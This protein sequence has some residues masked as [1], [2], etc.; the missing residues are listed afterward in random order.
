MRLLKI[1]ILA[2]FAAAAAWAQATAQIHGTVQDTSG[3]VIADAM[4]K[5]TQTDT[6]ISR[7]VTSAADGGYV[8]TNLPLGPYQIEVSKQGFATFV[9]TG[10]V[11]QVGSNPAV[12]IA[13]KIGAVTERVNV[14]A[15][16]T[17][18]E[19]TSAGVGSVV[20][21]QRIAA[22]PLN[23]RNPDDLIVLN[24]AAVLVG[25]NIAHGMQGSQLIAVA[26]GN[27]FGPGQCC[28]EV[29]N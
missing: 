17:Q 4:V 14:E 6:G 21:N 27:E 15:N 28:H 5:A 13:L 25:G 8:I 26:G 20:E 19:T 10:I 18:V 23:G 9:Q 11:L 2:A 16:A 3:A 1:G 22:L 7:T 12:P 24:G 29:R